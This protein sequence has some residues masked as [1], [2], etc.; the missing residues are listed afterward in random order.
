MMFLCPLVFG[1]LTP[2]ADVQQ[3]AARVL[4]IELLA[5][6]L[7]GVSIVAAERCAVRAM[8]VPS[9]LNLGSIWLVRVGSALVLVPRFGLVGMWCAM[10]VE[11]CIRGFA[12]RAPEN[13]KIL[14]RIHRRKDRDRK[15]TV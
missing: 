1:M 5:E 9:L 4:R 7:F 3:L 15:I 11:L 14:L 12:A 6:P 13:I 8:L 2:V 10:A